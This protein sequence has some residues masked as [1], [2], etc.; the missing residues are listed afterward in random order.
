MEVEKGKTKSLQPG[1]ALMRKE[2][3][4]IPNLTLSTD[5]YLRNHVVCLFV[6]LISTHLKCG[7]IQV[8][9][10]PVSM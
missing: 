5:E 4:S 10:L 3:R 1:L 8:E 6:R 2:L 7:F 9:S